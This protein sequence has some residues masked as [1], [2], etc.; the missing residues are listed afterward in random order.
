MSKFPP[1]FSDLERLSDWSLPTERARNSKRFGASLAELQDVY[2]TLIGRADDAF[3]LL[4]QT[5][6][7]N[8]DD[9]QKNLLNLYL[10]LAEVAFAVENYGEPAP[11]YLMRIDRFV[12]VHDTWA[13]A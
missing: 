9:R 4:N 12:P 1:Q 3:T 6:L 2:G 5:P 11:K 8:L 13:G 10:S 7:A